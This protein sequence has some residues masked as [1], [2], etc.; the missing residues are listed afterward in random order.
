MQLK[1]MQKTNYLIAK[2]LADQSKLLS[3]LLK[4]TSAE[5]GQ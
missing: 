4:N 5:Y 1:R 3:T 2:E